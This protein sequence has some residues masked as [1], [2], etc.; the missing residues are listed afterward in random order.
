[1]QRPSSRCSGWLASVGAEI[2]RKDYRL[3]ERTQGK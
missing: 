3:D 2:H 1:M